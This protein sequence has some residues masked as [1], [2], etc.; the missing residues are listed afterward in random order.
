MRETKITFSA[1]ERTDLVKSWLVVSVVFAI[2]FGGLGFNQQ[3]LTAIIIAAVTAGIGFLLH[4]L[5]HKYA[6]NYFG[7]SSEY[8]AHNT[9]LIFALLIALVFQA[10]FIAPGAVFVRGVQSKRENGIIS[11]AGP[12]TNIVL[13]FLFLAAFILMPDGIWGTVFMFGI[14]I[15][16]WLALFNMIPI[17]PFD[18]RKVWVWNKPIY[19]TMAAVSVLLVFGTQVIL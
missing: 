13:A 14:L 10:V 9:M 1:P 15:N 4:E 11:A 12:A 5:A 6:A 8:R 19:I 17:L 2:A 18:G 7:C 3:F 16:S